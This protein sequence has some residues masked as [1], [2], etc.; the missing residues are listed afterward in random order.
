[1]LVS[2]R[3]TVS[4]KNVVFGYRHSTNCFPD[5]F[6]CILDILYKT[7]KSKKNLHFYFWCLCRSHFDKGSRCCQNV[8]NKNVACFFRFN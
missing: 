7:A 4:K 8:R 5:S 1:V 3:Y 6:K 2:V